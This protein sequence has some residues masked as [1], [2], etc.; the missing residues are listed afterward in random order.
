M[1]V[2]ELGNDPRGP[3]SGRRGY[4]PSVLLKRLLIHCLVGYMGF[5]PI[6]LLADNET[7][8]PSSL[9]PEL[10]DRRGNAPRPS[11]L[12]GSTPPLRAAHCTL[13]VGVY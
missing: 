4:S 6:Y 11:I 10:V 13:G 8:T 7:T 5:E 12:Q 3:P 9:I 2:D 1:L